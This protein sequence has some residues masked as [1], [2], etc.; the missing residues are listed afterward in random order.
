MKP[1][2][3]LATVN[4]SC[5][6]HVASLIFAVIPLDDQWEVPS[7]SN[8][9]EQKHHLKANQCLYKLLDRQALRRDRQDTE[10]NNGWRLA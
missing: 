6:N 1:V 2:M 10:L 8:L 9:L 3:K 4:F 7:Y 5:K